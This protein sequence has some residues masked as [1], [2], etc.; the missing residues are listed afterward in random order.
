MGMRVVDRKKLFGAVLLL[1]CGGISLLWG[2]QMWRAIPGG[3]VDFQ[4]VYYGTRTLMDHRDPYN[5]NELKET[6]REQATK[7]PKGEVDTPQAVTWFIYQPTIFPVVAPFALLPW[8]VARM[9]WFALLVALLA[10]A[11]VWMWRVGVRLAPGVSLMLACGILL[12]CEVLFGG[13][14]SAG[15]AVSLCVLAAWCFVEERFALL[16]VLCM[17]MSLAIKP[18]D[19]GL[20]WLY[21]LIAG[22][23][24]RK[25]ALQTLGA[26]AVLGATALIWVSQSAPHWMQ[27]WHANVAAI[28]RPGYTSDP[29]IITG[30]VIDLQ[31]VIAVFR[32]DPRIYDPVAYAICGLLILAWAV[33]TVRKRVTVEHAWLALAAAVPITMLVTYHRPY[34]AKL[35]LLTIPACATLWAK[36]GKAGG[37]A[38][39]I[40]GLGVILTGDVFIAALMSLVE[41]LLVNSPGSGARWL[42]LTLTRAP[43]LALLAMAVFYLWVYWKK[44]EEGGKQQHTAAR[45]TGRL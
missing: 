1:V 12:N 38:L 42:I 31:A 2:V 27:Q 35:L 4:V 32:D 15:I 22:G 14:N 25:R 43:S 37:A 23:T 5:L 36:G 9:A 24:M 20:V 44:A 45:Y 33:A 28:S 29:G 30:T 21:F 26:A 10:T 40:T 6:Y 16:G 7:V 11:T 41:H 18:H 39:A 8:S 34:D 3:L 19:G 17:A 13:G